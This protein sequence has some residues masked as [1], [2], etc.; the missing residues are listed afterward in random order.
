MIGCSLTQR[1]LPFRPRFSSVAIKTIRKQDDVEAIRDFER[2]AAVMKDLRHPNL[3]QLQG[4]I[5]QQQPRLLVCLAP[6]Q[7]R[8]FCL[9]ARRL[10]RGRTASP[11]SDYAADG[12]LLSR[13]A[14]GLHAEPQRNA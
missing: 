12:R 10:S 8:Y 2:E 3:L 14:Q 7:R 1:A 5:L 9:W 11:L 4:V 13:P 6:T